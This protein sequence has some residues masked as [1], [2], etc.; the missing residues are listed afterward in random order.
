[1][2]AQ[3]GAP[4][5]QQVGNRQRLATQRRRIA[6]LRRTRG[7]RQLPLRRLRRRRP[8]VRSRLPNARADVG[9][10]ERRFGSAACTLDARGY[11]GAS[12]RP[13]RRGLHE[14]GR[15]R[16]GGDGETRLPFAVDEA[17]R[18][19]KSALQ[20]DR[21]G[22]KAGLRASV[23]VLAAKLH[24]ANARDRT[25]MLRSFGRCAWCWIWRGRIFFLFHEVGK[26]Y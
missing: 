16:D 18:R 24:I 14:C 7:R 19:V 5:L 9:W 17:Q 3:T 8:A 4:P 13:R 26:E 15:W 6:A 21:K 11:A 22:V 12:G 23:C 1:M 2:L 10:R 25:C 20:A